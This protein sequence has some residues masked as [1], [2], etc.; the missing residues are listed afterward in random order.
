M[1]SLCLR[2]F[3]VHLTFIVS[4]SRISVSGSRESS[5]ATRA[6]E[7]RRW[8]YPL[9]PGNFEQLI[10]GLLEDKENTRANIGE[11][12]IN[13]PEFAKYSSYRQDNKD[14]AAVFDDVLP[15]QSVFVWQQ[16]AHLASDWRFNNIEKYIDSDKP[17]PAPWTSQLNATAFQLSAVN[18][19][20]QALVDNLKQTS[21]KY[22]AYEVKINILRRGD[23]VD[24]VEGSS[25]G[26]EIFLLYFMRQEWKVNHYGELLL[27]NGQEI[28][29][30]VKPAFNRA[31]LWNS[32]LG[33]ISKPPSM[34]CKDS[35][36][37]VTVKYTSDLQKVALYEKERQ[38]YKEKKRLAESKMV[39]SL[40]DMT[41][42][43]ENLKVE[44]HFFKKYITE[45][46]KKIF[47]FDDM[48]SPK[49]LVILKEYVEHYG[50]YYF[51]DSLDEGNDNVQ[52]IS[53]LNIEPFTQTRLWKTVQKVAK[54]V[55]GGHLEW[56]PYDIACNNIRSFDS[57]QN[58]Q[59]CEYDEEEWTFL[60]YITPNLTL[61]SGGETAFYTDSE[62][63]EY[64]ISVT[65]KFGRA[66]IFEGIIPH[67]ARPPSS[68][69]P[70][71]RFTF[72][73]K[74][75]LKPWIAWKKTLK[76]EFAHEESVHYS[77][78]A[79][80]KKYYSHHLEKLAR[81]DLAVEQLFG[82][83]LTESYHGN[84]VCEK[85]GFCEP[86]TL[87]PNRYHA[88]S[89]EDEELLSRI[90]LMEEADEDEDDDR[91][92]VIDAEFFHE[93]FIDLKDHLEVMERKLFIYKS[94]NEAGWNGELNKQV[95]TQFLKDRGEIK[96]RYT[97]LLEIIF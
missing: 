29:S 48:F 65:P 86:D 13:G 77:G 91:L 1:A 51:D 57:T 26:D 52:W 63:N 76:Q 45:N 54:F 70:G 17:A 31:V 7:H 94:S 55:S 41:D 71:P 35:L 27:Y 66:V 20:F 38:Q 37:L 4:I 9:L 49:D 15:V 95:F 46:N 16:Y 83:G 73:V 72:A 39:E 92:D 69:F 53:A 33:Y 58:H 61:E 68:L 64:V 21:K 80:L 3:F 85:D 89:P 11:E 36:Y 60:L 67:S 18:T 50:E 2:I 78:L 44:D 93:S 81:T 84:D 62:T 23:F 10:N 40:V 32:S 12:E 42:S 88:D 90:K 87:G 28:V 43:Y 22:Y 82:E 56:F 30:S 24:L 74:L 97:Q 14:L 8:P 34:N 59:D 19:A 6:A 96:R 75:S 47:V 79:V 5:N 25:D